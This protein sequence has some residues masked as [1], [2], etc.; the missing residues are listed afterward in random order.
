[1]KSPIHSTLFL[2]CIEGRHGECSHVER[3]GL[4]TWVCQCECHPRDLASTDNNY[5]KFEPLPDELQ[6]VL[7]YSG[8]YRSGIPRGLRRCPECSEWRGL[9][10]ASPDPLE[11]HKGVTLRECACDMAG[12][13]SP[14]RRSSIDRRS[15]R[16][17][18]INP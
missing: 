6:E 13:M 5:D 17:V 16:R 1:M 12:R 11:W 2:C 3:P 7:R 14:G 8:H 15:S 9:H 10:L 4:Y 18:F